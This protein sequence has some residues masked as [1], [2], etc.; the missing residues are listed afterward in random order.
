MSFSIMTLHAY[1]ECHY[2]DCHLYSGM[3]KAILMLSVVTSWRFLFTLSIM[4]FGILPFIISTL[5]A[6]ADCHYADC[7]HADCHYAD[8]HYADCH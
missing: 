3:I 1:A 7:H 4:T 2:D 6:Y 5:Y 8:C